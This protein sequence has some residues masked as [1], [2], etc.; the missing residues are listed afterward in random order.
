[1]SKNPVSSRLD[2]A[3]FAVANRLTELLPPLR[4]VL[5]RASERYVKVAQACAEHGDLID[6]LE[7]YEKAIRRWPNDPLTLEDA[8]WVAFDSGRFAEAERFFRR[9]LLL[10]YDDQRA[11]G[12]LAFALHANG[13]TDEAIYRYLRYLDGNPTDYDALL[14]LGSLLQDSGRDEQAIEYARRAAQ[15]DPT[16]SDPFY[17][18]AVSHYNLG[19]FAEAE[20]SVRE[21]IAINKTAESLRLLGLLLENQDKP[22]EALEQFA[23]ACTVNPDFGDAWLDAGR[24]HNKLGQ[25]VQYLS[26]VK[27]GVEVLEKFGS[28]TEIAGAYWDLGWAYYQNKDYV[29][30]VAASRKAL[31]IAPDAAPPRFNLGLAFLF[32]N[33]PEAAKK[34]YEIAV[35]HSNVSDIERDGVEDLEAALE[36]NPQLRGAADILAMLRREQTKLALP[37]PRRAKFASV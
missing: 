14:N 19:N 32:M 1:M 8:G 21:A 27:K 3:L 31:D 34:E 22:A 35:Q 29:S 2:N 23:E 26:C 15:V 7:N 12:G 9:A 33:E 17:N 18:M 13:Q 28:S 16:K 24:V 5:K 25:Y 37:R 6:A 36:A 20:K 11:L 10:N 4:D 30:S